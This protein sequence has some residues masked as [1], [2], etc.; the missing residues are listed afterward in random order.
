MLGIPCARFTKHQLS[1]TTNLNVY[2]SFFGFGYVRGSHSHSLPV[3]SL[4]DPPGKRGKCGVGP[5]R[6]IERRPAV[7]FGSTTIVKRIRQAVLCP[8][9]TPKI[10]TRSL[11]H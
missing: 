10:V 11:R 2:A 4:Q 5:C 9:V 3:S 6:E 1:H 7:D 8:P